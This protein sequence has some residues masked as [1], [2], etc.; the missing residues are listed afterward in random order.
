M[1]EKSTGHGAAGWRPGARG[2]KRAFAAVVGVLAL[3]GLAG[4]GPAISAH[5]H[6]TFLSARDLLHMTDQMA[7]SLAGSP[8]LAAL[9]KNGPMVIVLKRVSN[10]TDEILTRG[11]EELF[12]HRVRVL[13]AQQPL[14]R[15][16]FRFVLNRKTYYDLLREEQIPAAQLGPR[17]SRVVPQ[18]VLDATFYSDTHVSRKFRSDYYL[19]AYQL[20]DIHTGVIVWQNTYETK[21]SAVSGFLY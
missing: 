8:R 21:K 19:C 6:T 7:A 17:E 15:R 12:V 5:A 18:Y 11:E 4:C 16:R 14:L 10:Q 13:L 9:T 1:P 20:V 3:T 2:L